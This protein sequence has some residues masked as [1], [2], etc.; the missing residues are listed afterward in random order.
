[1]TR[2]TVDSDAVSGAASAVAGTVSRLQ[3][4]ANAMHTQ[5]DQLQSSWTGTAATAF[6]GVVQQWRGAQHNLEQAL[7]SIDQALRT[8]ATQYAEIE[9]ANA[10]LFG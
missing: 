7:G 1:M 9:Q 8:A 2:F 3:A 4:E 6:A 5:L 10:R